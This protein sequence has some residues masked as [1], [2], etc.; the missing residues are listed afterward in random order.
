MSSEANQEEIQNQSPNS[1]PKNKEIEQEND[2]ITNYP[3]KNQEIE[4]LCN[5][6]VENLFLVNPK[7]YESFGANNIEI[8]TKVNNDNKGDLKIENTDK[9]YSIESSPIHE[10]N[11]E[12]EKKDENNEIINKEQN[13][14]IISK[15]NNNDDS[16]KENLDIENCTCN[17]F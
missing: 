12:I 1:S 7:N 2:N 3:Y 10:Q 17:I 11:Q 15:S 9:K 4:K 5:N 13:I 6:F 16:D 8:I 14:N